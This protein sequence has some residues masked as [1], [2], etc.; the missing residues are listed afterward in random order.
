VYGPDAICGPDYA[1][2]PLLPGET[3]R[4]GCYAGGTDHGEP[5][6]PSNL[7]RGYITRTVV[8][9]ALLVREQFARIT[10]ATPSGRATFAAHMVQWITA[11]TDPAD[12]FFR[13]HD[14]GDFFSP[15]YIDAWVQVI[16]ATPSIRYWAPTRSWHIARDK[17]GRW[18]ASFA[19][20]NLLPNTAIRPSALQRGDDAP[21]LP[22]WAAGSGVKAEG[23]N[24]PAST[25]NNECQS[26]RACWSPET[27][28]YYHWH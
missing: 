22:G 21:A 2:H 26:C 19:A 1:T 20:L 8:R 5:T 9:R 23:W 13:V 17:G 15:S 24:C 28:I 12:P 3:P 7:Q 25:T 16:A 6:N 4:K 11:N 27:A 14:S 18:A 10:T